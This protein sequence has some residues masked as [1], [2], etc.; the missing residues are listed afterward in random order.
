MRNLAQLGEL[1]RFGAEYLYSIP[2]MLNGLSY[3]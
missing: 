2:D 1:Y 3:S